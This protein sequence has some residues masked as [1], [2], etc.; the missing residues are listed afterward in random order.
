[1][2]TVRGKWDIWMQSIM[3][4]HGLWIKS[5]PQKMLLP[6]NSSSAAKTSEQKE[7]L[8]TQF[9]VCQKKLLSER[10]KNSTLVLHFISHSSKILAFSVC[11]H[12]NKCFIKVLY[13]F[14]Q[15][16]SGKDIKKIFHIRHNIGQRPSGK[17]QALE[18]IVWPAPRQIRELH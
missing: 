12:K 11:S 2:Q 9:P 18:R 14:S 13:A 7:T 17:G 8:Y 6:I 1:M 3:P 4:K 5:L 15:T 16:L 10:K